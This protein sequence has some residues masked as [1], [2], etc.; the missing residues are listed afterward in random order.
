MATRHGAPSI[1]N[2]GAA[3]WLP[4]FAYDFDVVLPF[5]PQPPGR[6]SYADAAANRPRRGTLPP[7]PALGVGFASPSTPGEAAPRP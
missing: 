1:P 7:G 2:V 4:G 5:P 3:T 6:L